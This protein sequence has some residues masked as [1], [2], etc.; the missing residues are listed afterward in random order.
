[1]ICLAIASAF[2]VTTH[3]AHA[4]S[5][6]ASGLY[7]IVSGTYDVCCGFG[8][9]II[10][11]LPNDSQRFIRMTVDP[12]THL[13]TMT[14]FSGDGQTA[15]SIVPCPPGDPIE[16]S[17][18]FGFVSSNSIVFQV[19]PGPPPYSVAWNYAVSNLTDRLRIDGTLGMLQVLCADVPN[20]FSHSNVV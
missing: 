17:F 2:V 1:I 19:D 12:Q 13:S 10:S 6:A 18:D 20:R 8:G 14:F 11:A 4:Q 5:E 9:D 3:S 16:F 7:Q 15:F